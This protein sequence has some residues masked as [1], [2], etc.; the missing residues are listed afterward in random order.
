M[1]DGFKSVN[2]IKIPKLD[3]LSSSYARKPQKQHIQRQE[4][5]KEST[6]DVLRGQSAYGKVT[7]AFSQSVNEQ[8]RTCVFIQR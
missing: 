3:A 6:A 8:A 5:N 7:I 4:T 2:C 1:R